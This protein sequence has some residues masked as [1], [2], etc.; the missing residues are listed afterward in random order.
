MQFINTD[1]AVPGLNRDLAHSRPLTIPSPKTLNEFLLAAAPIHQQIEKLEE[2]NQ[3][4]A[5]AR[6]ILL[7]RL[8]K[9][10]LAV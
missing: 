4:L 6:D 8:M 9:G 3:K 7:P 2:L 10:E 5:Q 1:V